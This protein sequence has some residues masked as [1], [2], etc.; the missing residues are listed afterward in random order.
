MACHVLFR[1]GRVLPVERICAAARERGVRTV[2]DGAH[3][4]GHVPT[5]VGQIGCD[6]YGSLPPAGRPG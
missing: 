5:D 4:F 3:G 2:I 1:N 6:D